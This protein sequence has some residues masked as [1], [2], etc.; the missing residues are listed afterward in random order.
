MMA[1]HLLSTV[2]MATATPSDRSLADIA[3]DLSGDL[4]RLV[5]T[6]I[7]LAKTEIQQNVA[8]LGT[9]A[10]LLGG[11]GFI[12]VFALEFVLLAL[13]FGLTALGLRLWLSALIVAVVLGIV[14]AVMVMTGKKKMQ[15]ASLAPTHAIEQ[16]KSDVETIKNDLKNVRIK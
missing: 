8:R 10:G 6:E 9:G 3:K 12:G 1:I 7:A 14:A 5:H 13:M 2:R 15:G 11:A 4:S 16:M